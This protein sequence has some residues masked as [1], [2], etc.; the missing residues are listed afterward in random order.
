M[1]LQAAFSSYGPSFDCIFLVTS[2]QEGRESYDE[3]HDEKP[4]REIK[5]LTRKIIWHKTGYN[6]ED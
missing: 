1:S 2:E 6:G 5:P 4:I 3:E